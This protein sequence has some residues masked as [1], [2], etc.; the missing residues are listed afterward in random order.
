M[1]PRLLCV[2]C[3]RQG[4]NPALPFTVKLGYDSGSEVDRTVGTTD[5]IAILDKNLA[6]LLDVESADGIGSLFA[7]TTVSG[8]ALC[9]GHLL[10]LDPPRWTPHRRVD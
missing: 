6:I 1:N 10:Q 8:T 9:L 2:V 5:L 4:T 3:L 7:V